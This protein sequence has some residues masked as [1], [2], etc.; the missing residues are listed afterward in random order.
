MIRRLTYQLMIPAFSLAL[1]SAIIVHAQSTSGSITGTVRDNS[2]APITDASVTVSN[3]STNLVR[4]LT[5]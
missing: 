1:L 5:T 4:Q 2:G 3:P